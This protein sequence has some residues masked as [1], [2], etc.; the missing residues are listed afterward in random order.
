MRIY[1]YVSPHNHWI[2]STFI[3]N[4]MLVGCFNPT[5]TKAL[6]ERVGISWDDI[7]FGSVYIF[8]GYLLSNDW[9]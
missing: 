2:G 1:Y 5:K 3:K 9:D 6:A 7:H 8:E 4:E